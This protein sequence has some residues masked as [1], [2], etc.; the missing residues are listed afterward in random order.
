VGHWLIDPS[1]DPEGEI[2][3]GPDTDDLESFVGWR[4]DEAL[5]AL[6]S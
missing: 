3:P 1:G 5:G 6:D 4:I 2:W